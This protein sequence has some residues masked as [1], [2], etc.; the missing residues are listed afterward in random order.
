MKIAYSGSKRLILPDCWTFW[1]E[2]KTL[3]N[4]RSYVYWPKMHQYAARSIRGCVL[5]NTSKPINC[6]LRLYVSSCPEE[7]ISVDLR[8]GYLRLYFYLF[9]VVDHFSQMITL[10]KEQTDYSSCIVWKWFGLPSSI[11]SDRDSWFL[12]HF[13]RT[14][15]GLMDT[16]Q[17]R[18][19]SFHPQTDGH[20]LLTKH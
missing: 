16:K 10:M 18:S 3:L 2:K 5:H 20:K 1:V 19:T 4:S 13:W 6:K 11:I 17:I 14:L 12:G 9:I 7:S 15:W 8:E